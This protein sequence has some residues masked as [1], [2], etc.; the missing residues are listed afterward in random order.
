[1][2]V[3]EVVLGLNPVRFGVDYGA[4]HIPQNGFEHGLGG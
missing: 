3:H 4:V 1:V 2:R